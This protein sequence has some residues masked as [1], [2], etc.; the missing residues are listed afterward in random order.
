MA[1]NT[2]FV[3]ASRLFPIQL[4][5]SVNRNTAVL[6]VRCRQRSW[7]LSLRSAVSFILHNG[8]EVGL[9][10]DCA[11]QHHWLYY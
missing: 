10:P 11:A 6:P 3:V 8:G 2:L 5:I 1:K 4:C 9:D 7:A